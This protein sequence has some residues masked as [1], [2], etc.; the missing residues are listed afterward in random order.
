LLFGRLK[1]AKKGLLRDLNPGRDLNH[2]MRIFHAHEL[3][4]TSL[5]VRS[6]WEQAGFG[7][8]GRDGTWHLY[9]HETKIRT[10]PEFMEV[11]AINYPEER[12]SSQTRQQAW[13][14]L[15]QQCSRVKYRK[16]LHF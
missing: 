2:V 11:W 8:E 4:T 16:A 10:S 14:W 1:A 9:V 7:F 12:L 15:T 5:T 6:S 3:A 13:R